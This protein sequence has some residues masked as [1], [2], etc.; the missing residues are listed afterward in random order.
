MCMLTQT[1]R[2]TKL[3]AH[4]ADV[5]GTRTFGSKTLFHITGLCLTALL[6]IF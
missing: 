2:L 4:L 5:I 6:N 1:F 3:S